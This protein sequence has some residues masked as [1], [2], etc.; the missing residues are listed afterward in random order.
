MSTYSAYGVMRQ[1]ELDFGV[2]EGDFM[3]D[4]EPLRHDLHL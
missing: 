2:A 3:K 4:L 1:V